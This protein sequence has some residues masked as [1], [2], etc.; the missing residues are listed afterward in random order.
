MAL[1]DDVQAILDRRRGRRATSWV[2]P[3][4]IVTGDGLLAAAACG[5]AVG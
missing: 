3:P 1:Q 4:K 2:Q 5:G